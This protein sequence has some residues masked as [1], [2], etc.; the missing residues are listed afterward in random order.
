M[1]WKP[2]DNKDGPG[3]VRNSEKES[4]GVV[5]S[6]ENGKESLQNLMRLCLWANC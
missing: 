6:E 3:V 2:C 4:C 5:V 1:L